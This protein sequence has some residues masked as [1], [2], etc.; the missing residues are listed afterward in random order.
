MVTSLV[1]RP[2]LSLVWV[3]GLCSFHLVRLS[4]PLLGFYPRLS[5]RLLLLHLGMV[6][7][8]STILPSHHSGRGQ[9]FRSLWGGLPPPTSFL[10]GQLWLPVPVIATCGVV[11]DSLAWFCRG[12]G[13]RGPFLPVGCIL[14]Q[15]VFPFRSSRLFSAWVSGIVFPSLF[16]ASTVWLCCHGRSCGLVP[17]NIRICQG[18]CSLV[19]GS[20]CLIQSHLPGHFLLLS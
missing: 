14:P 10:P 15:P 18:R 11:S 2:G 4:A 8:L 9:R 1:S 12:Q 17:C 13:P 3:F 5:C 20:S 7:L 6:L 19:L 16:L